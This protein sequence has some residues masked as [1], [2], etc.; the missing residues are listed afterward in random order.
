MLKNE[1]YSHSSPSEFTRLSTLYLF[2][3]IFILSSKVSS[4]CVQN[5]LHFSYPALSQLRICRPPT[6]P[7]LPL[8]KWPYLHE[9]CVMCW[10]VWKIN[11]LIFVYFIFRVMVKWLKWFEKWRILFS[12]PQDA[13]CSETDLVN[14]LFVQFILVQPVFVQSISSSPNLT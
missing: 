6:P 8:Q 3:I 9:R 14:L 4:F 12:V 2:K 7:P 5:S 10:N 13:K 1:P 11:F